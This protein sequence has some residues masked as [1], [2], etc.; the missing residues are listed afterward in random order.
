MP[1]CHAMMPGKFAETERMYPTLSDL[2]GQSE[3][4]TN[5]S[6]P[7]PPTNHNEGEQE[8]KH[9]APTK[10]SLLVT[11]TSEIEVSDAPDK[12]KSPSAR[13]PFWIEDLERLHK[14]NKAGRI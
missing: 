3:A 8:T 2:A 5:P 9:S 6:G 11:K 14:K 13:K 7:S 10:K 1:S 4:K 12:K